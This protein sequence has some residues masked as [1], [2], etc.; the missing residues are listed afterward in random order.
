MLEL[1]SATACVVL[2][3]GR[4][5]RPLGRSGESVKVRIDRD[6]VREFLRP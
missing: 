2:I 5:T 4:P 6:S 1:A 3:D